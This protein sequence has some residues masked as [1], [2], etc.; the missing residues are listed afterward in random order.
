MPIREIHPVADYLKLQ[1]RFKHLFADDPLAREEL[2]HLQALADHNIES[3]ALKG[4]APDA[5]DTE[6]ADTVRRGG[7]HFA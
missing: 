5:L 6:G 3:Y 4:G 7:L 1:G 2:A